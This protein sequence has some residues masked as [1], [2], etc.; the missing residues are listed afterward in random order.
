MKSFSALVL[1][2]LMGLGSVTYLDAA[3][4]FGNVRDRVQNR[5]RVC[6]YQDIRYQ[7]W[8][9]CYNAGDEVATLERRNNA[10]SSI[11]IYGR[12]R[13][14]VY[15]DTQFRGRS[16]EFTSD[17]ADLGLRNLSGSRSWSDHISSFRISSDAYGGNNGNNGGYGN[18]GRDDRDRNNQV[19][20]GIC[21]YDRPDYQ[22]RER[23]FDAGA[24]VR[25]LGSVGNWSDRISS[26]RV[27]GRSAAILYRDINYN[28]DSVMIDRDIPD[29]RQISGGGF[30]NWDHQVSSLT[31]ERDRNNFP[32]G[33]ARGWRR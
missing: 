18:N 1:T 22:G 10:V 24:D 14:T 21:V 23:C 32:R 7:G 26:I 27:F 6:F 20:N 9:Q 33:R 19:S 30:R 4:Q 11:R 25:D 28:G 13:V 5:D 31:V 8:E 15:E 17:V 3:P 2:L 12:A 29:L 16:A